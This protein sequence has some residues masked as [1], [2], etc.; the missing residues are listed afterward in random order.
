MLARVIRDMRVS[1]RLFELLRPF[2]RVATD[3]R[4]HEAILAAVEAGDARAARRA[5]AE[6]LRAL[7]RY[8]LATLSGAA[9]GR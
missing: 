6:H 5:M 2:E 8:V 4:E 9:P 1:T 3:A 7:E